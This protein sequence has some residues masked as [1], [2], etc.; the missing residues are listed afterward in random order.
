MRV[1]RATEKKALEKAKEV[2]ESISSGRAAAPNLTPAELADCAAALI[3]IHPRSLLPVVEEFLA[4]ESILGGAGLIEA[5]RFYVAAS[6]GVVPRK[7]PDAVSDFVA[8][9]EQDGLSTRHVANLRTTLDRF[10]LEYTLPVAE[11]TSVMLDQWLRKVAPKPRTRHNFKGTLSNF[12]AFCKSRRYLPV[13]WD[14]LSAVASPRF[15]STAPACYSPDQFKAAL[16]AAQAS[17]RPEFCVYLIL[18]GMLG[19]RDAEA[20]RIDASQL[21]EGFIVVEAGQSKVRG[22]RRLI[23]L[24]GT[25]HDWLWGYAPKQGPIITAK[26]TGAWHKALRELFKT[27]EVPRLHNGLR[28]S[29]I[30]Y[31]MALTRDAARVADEA[32]NSPAKIYQHYREISLPDG[33]LITEQMANEWFSVPLLDKT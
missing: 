12:F 33:Q 22:R 9:K 30:S 26:F 1:Y 21:R 23:T 29:Y 5:A 8:A 15:Q 20:F 13:T 19:I 4:A 3:R 2:C 17:G 25:S 27:A 16:R 7:I 18:R 32:G 11:V 28:D 6:K 24:H 10:K 14:E 31:R